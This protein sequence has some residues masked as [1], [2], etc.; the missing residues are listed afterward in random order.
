MSAFADY[1]NEVYLKGLLGEQPT[2]PFGWREMRDA[3]YA[4]MTPQAI[5]YVEGSAGTEDTALANREA[6]ARWRLVPRMLRGIPAARSLTA[7]SMPVAST[8]AK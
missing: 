5:G 8:E 3:A 1:Q 7:E 2:L 4:V 6:F